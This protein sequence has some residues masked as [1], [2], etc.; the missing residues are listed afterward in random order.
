MFID[1][2]KPGSESAQTVPQWVRAG[3]IQTDLALGYG[4]PLVFHQDLC[5]HGTNPSD[6]LC[7]GW[8]K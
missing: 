3:S 1:E 8:E 4:T 2:N 6:C 7:T 5:S